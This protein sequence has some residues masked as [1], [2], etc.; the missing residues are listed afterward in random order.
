MTI[1]CKLCPLGYPPNPYAA[2]DIVCN[3]NNG[4]T[5]QVVL[6]PGVYYIRAQGAGGKGGNYGYPYT[7]GN[8]AP[9]GA[10]F[11]GYIRV[12]KPLSIAVK[13][14]VG[15]TPSSPAG[16]DTTIPLIMNLGGGS[17]GPQSGYNA[18]CPAGTAGVI[19]IYNNGYFRILSYTVNSDGNT[20]C[21]YDG[22]DSVITKDGGGSGTGAATSPGAGGGGTAAI[23]GKGG[24]GGYGECLIR[25]I[26]P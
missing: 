21:R 1:P 6:Y 12:Y 17:A 25:F 22:G 20:G 2:N 26:R 9:S 4:A 15:G 24:N 8:G 13:T 10:G 16:T 19:T 18:I 3:I 11:V 14:G 5:K 7:H 23:G